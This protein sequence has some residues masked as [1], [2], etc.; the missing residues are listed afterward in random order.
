MRVF[1]V[2]FW[3]LH[4]WRGRKWP[5]ERRR[6]FERWQAAH[7]AASSDRHDHSPARP[8]ARPLARP[9]ACLLARLPPRLACYRARPKLSLRQSA[10]CDRPAHPLARTCTCSRS[11][12]P[13]I[14]VWRAHMR[15][16]S[17]Q[18]VSSRLAHK[19]AHMRA[20]ARAAREVAKGS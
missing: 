20:R 17:A 3:H 11:H 12:A 5:V 2:L 10:P 19:R 14:A 16:T 13:L 1:F 6:R 18:L 4:F 15:V 9:L 8:P 7:K